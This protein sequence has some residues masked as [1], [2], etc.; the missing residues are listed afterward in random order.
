MAKVGNIVG[1]LALAGAALWMCIKNVK[2]GVK[3]YQ[4]Q[5]INTSTGTA[6]LKVNVEVKNPLIFGVKITGIRGTIWAE[7]RQIGYVNMSYNYN[8]GGGKTHIIPVVINIQY[9]NAGGAI[10]T[11]W[12]QGD[13]QDMVITFDGG[14]YIGNFGVK[15]PIR[16]NLVWGDLM[17]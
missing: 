14:V 11:N 2:V 4:L 12:I 5:G 10:V 1:G 13:L 16:L 7:G 17:A 6:A 8:L 9:Q 3:D 15:I